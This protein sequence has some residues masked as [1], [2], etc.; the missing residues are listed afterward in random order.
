M[1]QNISIIEASKVLECS[2]MTIY[3]HIKR[4]KNLRN[5][6]IKKSNVQ[7]LTPEGLDVFKELIN[8]S[9]SNHSK[10]TVNGQTFLQP[11]MYKTLIATKD[12]HIDSLIE[13][14]KE[15]DKQIETQNRL[16]ENNQVL[17]QQS[18]QKILY[19]ES[20]DK[21]KKSLPWWK[22]IFS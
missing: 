8:S 15:K 17:L 20:M 2:K 16:L 11:N 5:Y 6:I 22:K 21:E 1:D 3:N 18:Q 4:N 19:L 14:L 9:K 10:W 13:Q 7:Y 12:K